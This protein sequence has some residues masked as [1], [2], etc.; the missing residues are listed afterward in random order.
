MFSEGKIRSE[1]IK[2]HDQVPESDSFKADSSMIREEDGI[3]LNNDV[4]HL[5]LN[6]DDP[7]SGTAMLGNA[8]IDAFETPEQ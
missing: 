4:S 5:S 6:R 1:I 2:K 7:N 3:G 8:F